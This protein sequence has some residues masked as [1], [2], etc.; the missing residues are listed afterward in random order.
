MRSAC[1]NHRNSCD[2]GSSRIHNLYGVRSIRGRAISQLSVTIISRPPDRTVRFQVLRVKVSGGDAD[3]PGYRGTSRVNHLNRVGPVDCGAVS[4][5]S[6]TIF[7]RRPD[8]P[9]G[10]QKHGVKIP[11]CNL[12][13]TGKRRTTGIHNL[14][15]V[16][17]IRSGTVPQLTAPIPAHRP[18]RAVRFQIH[19]MI[20]ARGNRMNIAQGVPARVHDLNRVASIDGSP[21][22]KLAIVIASRS[23]NRTVRLQIDRVIWTSGNPDYACKRRTSRVHHLHGV[24][25]IDGRPVSQLTVSILSRSP[26]RAVGLEENRV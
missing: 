19:R 3:H 15:G 20:K 14:H 10:F 26:D 22:T 23:P 4:Q 21:I 1:G 18:D 13:Y 5:A 24:A 12:R 17:A 8:R 11:R 6:I 7:S 2:G 16:D 25:S 9:V